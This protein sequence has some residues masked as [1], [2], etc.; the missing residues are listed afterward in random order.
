MTI[1][2][3]CASYRVFPMQ[4]AG[5]IS[6]D[7]AVSR[8]SAQ[9]QPL[10]IETIDVQSAFGRV[11]G[12]PLTAAIDSPRTAVSAM[13]GFAVHDADIQRPN[14]RLAVSQE[15]FA[16]V[17]ETP[18]A[19]ERG[20]CARIFTGAPTPDGADRVVIQE[21]VERIGDEAVF[22]GPAGA[23]RNIRPAGADFRA[24]AQLLDAGRLL[25]HRSIV[26]AAAADRATIAVYRR[27]TILVVSTGDELVAPGRAADQPGKIPE[28]LSLGVEALA[29]Q[30]G[31]DVLGRLRLA[32]DPDALRLAAMRC[33]ERADLTVVTG[34]ASVGDRDFAK[35]MFEGADVEMQF[36][37]VA[38]K[39]GKPVWFARV[40]N[41]LVLG[42]PGNPTSAMVT[43]RLFLAPL[44]AGLAGRSP[45]SA[46]AWR[47]MVLA[48]DL[49]ASGDR[50]TLERGKVEAEGVRSLS[51]QDSASQRALAMADVLIRRP[52]GDDARQ[53]GAQVSV[54]DF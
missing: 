15:I 21:D 11:L 5:L 7:E 35:Q 3:T 47:D 43:A 18:A 39:P 27:P 32:D 17:S 52:P 40:N 29:A 28:S 48:A 50:E 24:G 4:H 9:A 16:G 12:L 41:R 38:I 13:D 30:W 14:A 45:Q 22:S 2:L 33:L 36:S 46:L 44:V 31:G 23:R 53:A 19:L 49:D 25:D 51:D 1:R 54:L 8:I 34:G 20:T 10:G 42:L 37:K 6:L 26:T